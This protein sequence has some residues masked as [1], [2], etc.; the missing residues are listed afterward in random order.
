V[1]KYGLLTATLLISSFAQAQVPDSTVKQIQ[2]MRIGMNEAGKQLSMYTDYAY[3]G[4]GLQIA[5]GILTAVGLA[6]NGGATKN[7]GVQTSPGTPIIVLGGVTSII[8]IFTTAASHWYVGRAGLTLRQ[9][10]IGI[11][12]RSK[13]ER[14]SRQATAPAH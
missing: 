11:P 7:S 10:S 6:T 5:G 12:I 14:R 4:I 1:I 2:D 13:R 9:N 3:T 8:G